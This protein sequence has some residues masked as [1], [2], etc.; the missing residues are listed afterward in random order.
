MSLCNTD[1]RTTT[2]TKIGAAPAP[3]LF[4]VRTINISKSIRVS[5]LLKLDEFVFLDDFYIPPGLKHP[6]VFL[7]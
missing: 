7:P 3:N 1:Y 4:E 6:G 5:A 2:S